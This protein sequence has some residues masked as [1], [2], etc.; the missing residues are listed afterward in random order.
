[1]KWNMLYVSGFLM[2]LLS[3]ST[4]VDNA[5]DSLLNAS[6]LEHLYQEVEVGDTLLGTVWIYCEA[7]DYKV[8][9]DEDE[10]FTCVDD[11]AR[12]L[13]F[14]CRQYQLDGAPAALEKIR[15]L[16]E[17]IL[18][19]QAENGY[20][21]NFLLPDKQINRQ[22]RNSQAIPNW[23]SWRAFWALSEVNLLESDALM[24]LQSRSLAAMADLLP[25]I[26]QLCL[27]Q[28]DTIEIDGVKIPQCLTRVGADQMG[29]LMIGLANHYRI[30]PSAAAKA[31]MLRFGNLL[32]AV[33]FG[34]QDTFP[35]GAFMS[36]QNNWHAWGNVQAYALLHAGRVLQHPPFI[37]AGL[38]EVKYYYPYCLSR[39]LISGFKV[40]SQSDSLLM[41]DGRQFPQIAYNIRPMVYASMEAFAIT[42]DTTYAR[43]AGQLAGWFFGDNPAHQQMYD[44]QSGRTFDGIG[45]PSDINFN[46]GAE[47]TIEALLSIQAITSSPVALEVLMK[48]SK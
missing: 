48:N 37:E 9:G 25:E 14:Y 1:M 7:P 47:S 6:H 8:V 26:E 29:V 19:M 5:E 17:F 39:G 10:G 40:V 24:E 28:E 16:T 20:F 4:S 3:C 30:W 45:S 42:G 27:G 21:Y 41:Q 18:Y 31:A 38:K 13:V 12:A 2:L 35:Y 11:V 33:Q 36:W 32:L 43:T 23:W 46:S 34:D 44:Q 15:S 22:H